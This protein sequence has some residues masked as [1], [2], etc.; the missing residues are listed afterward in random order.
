M[1]KYFVIILGLF[2]SACCETY[3]TTTYSYDGITIVR[4]DECGETSFYYKNISTKERIFAKYSG[5]NDGFK[6]YLK[7]EDGGKV[8]LLSGDGYFEVENIDTSKFEYKRIIAH[9][10]PENKENV[11]FVQLST[12]YEK[13]INI[14]SG[15]KVKAIY[16][17]QKK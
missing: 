12:R 14:D 2:F 3:V 4:V 5:I 13:K 7:F 10:R 11:Y 8:L 17:Y 9:Q 15:T 16:H 1:N 6:G